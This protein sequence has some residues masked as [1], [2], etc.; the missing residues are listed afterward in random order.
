MA[1]FQPLRLDIQRR[2]TNRSARVKAVDFHPTEPW[3]LTAL[4]TG[5]VHIWNYET[6]A[7]VK[8]FEASELP[9]KFI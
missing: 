8:T 9:R 1:S 7:L 4:Y 5:N 2:L 3:L 6:Q